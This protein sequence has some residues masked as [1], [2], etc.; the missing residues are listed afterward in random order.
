MKKS[1]L[2]WL[3]VVWVVILFFS[4]CDRA[5]H[6]TIEG[7]IL[8]IGAVANHG[9]S[10]GPDGTETYYYHRTVAFQ[11]RNDDV[12]AYSFCSEGF[13]GFQLK[14]KSTYR[15]V[16]RNGGNCDLVTSVVTLQQ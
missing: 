16:Y 9:V 3:V 10:T 1:T 12:S 13:D 15:I 6:T 5:Q 11:H 2:G 14:P 7:K 4:A 8:A